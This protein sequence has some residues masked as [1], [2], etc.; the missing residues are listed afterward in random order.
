[1]T[2]I[3]FRLT[4]TAAVSLAVF[5]A[6][7]AFAADF[8]DTYVGY[9][10]GTTF[11]EPNNGN[12]IEKNIFQLTHASGYKYG[13]N[14]FNVDTFISD[15]A[16]RAN[17][18]AA[19]AQEIYV[20]YRT[21]LSLGKTTGLPTAFGPVRDVA[22]TAGFDFNSKDTTFA[23]RKRAAVFGPTVKFNVPGFLDVSVLYY[24]ESNH[25]G[26][27]GTIRPDIRFDDT[28]MLSA[29]WGIPFQP[30][31]LPM[32]F[33]GF[34]NYSL[35]KGLDYQN[36]KTAPETLM[37]TSLMLDVG[38]LAFDKKNTLWA[39]VGYEYWKNKFGNQPGNGTKVNA[40]Q[41]QLEYHF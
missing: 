34:I 39:G 32:K 1:M 14:Y 2:S 3:S 16:D 13:S 18:S 9:R 25:R 7:G 31:G 8:S 37:R 20:L 21:Q 10:H 38:Q 5:G 23:P 17:N 6:S 40:A 28:T 35:E 4:A 24:R 36:V 12:N 30:A 15:K 29:S 41:A 26:I 27:P 22:L 33:Q 19:G 11:R